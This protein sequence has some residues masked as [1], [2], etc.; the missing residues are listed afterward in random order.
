M[1]EI[2]CLYPMVPYEDISKSCGDGI[3]VSC[4]LT[5]LFTLNVLH[6]G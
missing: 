5:T 4:Q 3:I 2:I 1:Y 6:S